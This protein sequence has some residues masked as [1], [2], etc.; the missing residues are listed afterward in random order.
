[1]KSPI[2]KS[3]KINII[4][5]PHQGELKPDEIKLVTAII[6]SSRASLE[7]RKDLLQ[8]IVVKAFWKMP[9]EYTGR[10]RQY[11]LRKVAR[12]TIAESYRRS[13]YR[14]HEALSEDV[15]GDIQDKQLH[16]TNVAVR[17]ALRRSLVITGEERTIIQLRFLEQY[18]C[19]RIAILLDK[20]VGSIS[21]LLARA[22]EKLRDDPSFLD[23]N[24]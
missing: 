8:E 3:E 17:D 18:E 13:S 2:E 7:D 6:N 22:L 15:H 23:L 4:L 16:V 14:R 1:M 21:Y 12:H 5:D 24:E 20:S 10:L 19:E 9:R 11:W